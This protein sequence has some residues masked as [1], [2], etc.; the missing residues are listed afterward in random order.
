M[1]SAQLPVDVSRETIERLESLVALMKKW[2]AAINLVARSTLDDAWSRHIIDSA[3]LF[4][5]APLTA[6]TWVDLGSGGG[7]PGLVIAIIAQEKTPELTV[8]LI[9]S[10]QRKAAF[11]RQANA[12]FGLN[13]HILCER[14]EAATGQNAEVVSARALAS[15]E[16][17]CGYAARHMRPD[18]CALF[19]KGAQHAAEVSNARKLWSFHLD[20]FPSL[21]DSN[22]VILKL[23]DLAHV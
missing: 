21:T 22:A 7:F 18:G 23:K 16:K 8:T 20:A 3:Q 15:L 17:L 14:I 1:K 11:L 5:L 4:S 6:K 19:L 13:C 12:S 9:E 2:N 10:D